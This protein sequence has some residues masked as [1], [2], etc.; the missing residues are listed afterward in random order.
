MDSESHE[1]ESKSITMIQ[2]W[3][4][5]LSLLLLLSRQIIQKRDT[6]E[7]RKSDLILI[8]PI[9]SLSSNQT[10]RDSQSICIC[11]SECHYY[12][13]FQISSSITLLSLLLDRHSSGCHVILFFRLINSH[14]VNQ[15]WQKHVNAQDSCISRHC[16]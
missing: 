9:S 12:N 15:K 8:W 13:D 1:A 5:I 6:S 14:D 3:Q 7:N 16:Q 4:I 11:S 10:P 2:F